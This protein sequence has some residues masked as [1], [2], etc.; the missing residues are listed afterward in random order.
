[1][2]MCANDMQIAAVLRQLR[3]LVAEKRC[4]PLRPKQVGAKRL[5][6][7]APSFSRGFLDGA[8]GGIFLLHQP[9]PLM[10]HLY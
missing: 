7:D 10:G 1:M 5:D 6:T 9:R 8:R 3:N 4:L 2:K